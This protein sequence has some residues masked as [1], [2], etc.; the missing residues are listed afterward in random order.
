MAPYP[1]ESQT[2]SIFHTSIANLLA[3]ESV[4][5]GESAGIGASGA[6]KSTIPPL[7]FVTSPV[8]GTGSS[9][10]RSPIISLSERSRAESRA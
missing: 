8:A 10:V 7:N 4:L 5:S 2:S 1:P 3:S 9:S 6:A